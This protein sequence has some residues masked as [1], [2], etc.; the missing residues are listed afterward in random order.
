MNKIYFVVFE[1]KI[2]RI[3]NMNMP[4]KNFPKGSSMFEIDAKTSIGNLGH[5]IWDCGCNAGFGFE[6]LH[7]IKKIW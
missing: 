1:K 6:Y 4:K 5:F 2:L 3:H 7:A